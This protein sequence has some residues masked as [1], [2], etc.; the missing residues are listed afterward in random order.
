[1][2]KLTQ[3][4]IY[5]NKRKNVENVLCIVYEAN[6]IKR[7][8]TA[9]YDGGHKLIGVE[10]ENDRHHPEY[11]GIERILQENKYFC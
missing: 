7:V 10:E 3:Y 1:M 8:F 5:L 9:Y 11:E 2:L 6:G 4:D